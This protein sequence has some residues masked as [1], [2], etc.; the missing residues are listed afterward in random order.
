MVVEFFYEFD[1]KL[2]FKDPQ[3]AVGSIDLNNRGTNI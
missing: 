3:A 2:I 1:D